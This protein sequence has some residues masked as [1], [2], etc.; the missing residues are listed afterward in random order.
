MVRPKAFIGLF[1]GESLG[2]QLVRVANLSGNAAKYA[3]IRPN[4]RGFALY[5]GKGDNSR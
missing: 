5:T 4:A 1:H 3:T 2:W